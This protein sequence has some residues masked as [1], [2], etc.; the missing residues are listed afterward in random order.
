MDDFLSTVTLPLACYCYRYYAWY[1]HSSGGRSKISFVNFLLWPNE[2]DIAMPSLL[3]LLSSLFICLAQGNTRGP[4][5][6]FVALAA[7]AFAWHAS[8]RPIFSEETDSSVRLSAWFMFMMPFLA[9]GLTTYK[10]ARWALHA[11]PR[12]GKSFG[13]GRAETAVL[14]QAIVFAVSVGHSIA[15]TPFR[16]NPRQSGAA[17]AALSLPEQAHI[18]AAVL[19]AGTALATLALVPAVKARVQQEEEGIS[20]R[21]PRVELT[22]MSIYKKNLPWVL[23]FQLLA[24]EYVAFWLILRREPVFVWVV[25]DLIFGDSSTVITF[26]WMLFAAALTIGCMALLQRVQN[27]GHATNS[28][29]VVNSPRNTLER[30][31]LTGRRSSSRSRS[32]ATR[33]SKKPAA[34]TTS[35]TSVKTATGKSLWL[36]LS[37][38]RRNLIVRKAFH[39]AA[40]LLFA[41]PLLYFRDSERVLSLMKVA[42]AGALH[43]FVFIELMRAALPT[44]PAAQPSSA[45]V[46]RRSQIGLLA[47]IDSLIDRASRAFKQAVDQGMKPFTDERD[48]GAFIL[49]HLYLMGGCGLPIWLS[50]TTLG[51]TLGLLSSVAPLLPLAGIL[52]CM[53]DAAAAVFGVLCSQLGVAITWERALGPLLRCLAPKGSALR[54]LLGRKTVHGTAGFVVVAGLLSVLFLFWAGVPLD[55]ASLLPALLAAV[56]SA[57]IETLTVGV[58]NL[59]LPLIYWLCLLVL[60]SSVSGII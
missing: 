56:I 52:S 59:L 38:S 23:A 1:W 32:P 31:A 48:G 21:Q 2:H 7:I 3:V 30:A 15:W 39:V 12:A 13:V 44:P 18:V 26:A 27:G 29:V 40:L 57:V 4:F 35:A 41:P 58:D 36:S 25:Q 5:A 10:A 46:S 22:A 54:E 53:G 50:S 16:R 43:V 42:S 45:V 19:I 11:W 28:G 34:G 24:F 37:L 60:P 33:R 55:R 8:G 47:R 14:L 49:T 51:S 6:S 9:I 17:Y 20:S